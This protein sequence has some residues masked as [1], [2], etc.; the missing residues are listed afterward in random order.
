M[1]NKSD[2]IH[3]YNMDSGGRIATVDTATNAR[4]VIDYAHHEIHSGSHFF[5]RESYDLAKN[6]TVDHLIVVPDTTKWPHMTIAVG[7][8]V[9]QVLVTLYEDTVVSA[10]GTADISYNRDRNSSNLPTTAIYTMPTVTSTGSA[11]ANM[12]LGA[13]KNLPGGEAR[14]SEEIILKQNSNYLLRVVEPNVAATVVNIV[15]DWYEHQNKTE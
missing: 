12:T 7:N 1:T 14:D 5:H 10:N 8:V 15:F 9:S 11:I 3:T 13:G 4:N 6:G 2:G